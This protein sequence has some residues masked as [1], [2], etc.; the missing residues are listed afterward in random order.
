MTQDQRIAGRALPSPARTL[1]APD[2]AARSVVPQPPDPYLVMS[3]GWRARI[4]VVI[5]AVNEADNLRW[6]LPQLANV[7]E[8]IV[9]DGESTDGTSD[10]VR[11]LCPH[12]TLIRQPRQGKGAAL[13]AGFGT[14]MGAPVSSQ[15]HSWDGAWLVTTC[16]S[17][18]GRTGRWYSNSAAAGSQPRPA[19]TSSTAAQ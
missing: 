15:M 10:V 1:A 18:P 17:W 3:S 19:R 13:R 8:V 11:E 9:V 5:P 2:G 16:R 6:L 14:A 7:D 12:A 4:S